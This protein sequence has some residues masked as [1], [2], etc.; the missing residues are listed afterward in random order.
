MPPCHPS[1]SIDLSSF[2]QNA[3]KKALAGAPD[4]PPL[5]VRVPPPSWAQSVKKTEILHGQTFR[6][7]SYT[8]VRQYSIIGLYNWLNNH[9]IGGIL[10][11]HED[12]C[13]TD[14]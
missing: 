13:I 4:T 8:R 6:V 10:V 7:F 12:I 11:F 2:P 5:T 9:N 1:P 3:H 14:L